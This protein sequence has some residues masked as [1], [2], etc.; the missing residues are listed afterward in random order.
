MCCPI[1]Y[2]EQTSGDLLLL[3]QQSSQAFYGNGIV[4]RHVS[5]DLGR[6]WLSRPV[7]EMD[8]YSLRHQPVETMIK[9]D[10][11]DLLMPSDNGSSPAGTAVH[12]SSGE[13]TFRVL[14]VVYYFRRHFHRQADPSAS[15]MPLPP[16]PLPV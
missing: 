1:L 11:G 16:T 5:T 12:L 2:A 14:I 15:A 8:F 3:S 13:R 6:S 9:L 4:M 7:A 10:N